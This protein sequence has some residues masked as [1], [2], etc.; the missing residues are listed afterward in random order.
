MRRKR[1]T[2]LF[3]VKTFFF[4]LL[5]I[6]K[7]QETSLHWNWNESKT[8]NNAGIVSILHNKKRTGPGNVTSKDPDWDW[9]AIA[10][11]GRDPHLVRVLVSLLL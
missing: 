2:F 3:S 8:G 10:T 4:E 7:L 11:P 5:L 1:R 6:G 9:F